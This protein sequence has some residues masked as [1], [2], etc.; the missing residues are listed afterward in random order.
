MTCCDPKR[1]RLTKP[2]LKVYYPDKSK[3][4]NR[5]KGNQNTLETPEVKK[6]K[7]KQPQ[8]QE[9]GKRNRKRE[10]TREESKKRAGGTALAQIVTCRII[11]HQSEATGS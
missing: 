8:D 7:T 6:E 4:Q 11:W 5:E 1:R 3:R 10:N 9:C 2:P